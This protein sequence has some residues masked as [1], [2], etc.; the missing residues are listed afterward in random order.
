MKTNSTRITLGIAFGFLLSILMGIGW[1]GLS[2][3]DQINGDLHDVLDQH[4]AKVQL[5]REVE[6]YSNQNERIAMEIFF[7]DESHSASL[8]ARR[9]VNRSKLNNVL[10]ELGET[11]SSDKERELLVKLKEAREPLAKSFGRVGELLTHN[12]PTEARQEMVSETIPLR[13]QFYIARDSFVQ[14][15]EHEMN[16]AREASKLKYA[17]ARRI[18]ILLILL[19][20][21]VAAIIAVL[22]TGKM[23]REVAQRGIAERAIQTLNEELEKKV[24]GRTEQLAHTVQQLQGEVMERRQIEVALRQSE[25]NFRSMIENSPYGI[26]RITPDHRIQQANRALLDM[27]GYAAESEVVGMNTATHL[28]SS[29]AEHK[30]ITEQFNNQNE[31][32]GVEVEWKRKDGSPLTVRYG[33]HTVLDDS[34]NVHHKEIIAED[35]TER[36]ALEQQLRQAQKMEA[37]GQLAGGVA[38]DFNNLLGVIIGYSDLLLDRPDVDGAIRK[39]AAQIKKAGERASSLTR[40]LLAFSRRQVFESK[41]VSL[42]T[43]IA[44]MQKMLPRIIGEDIEMRTSFDPALGNVRADQGQIEQVIMNLAVNARDAMPK[45]GALIFETANVEVPE[46]FTS[47]HSGMIPGR[48]V[49]LTVSDTGVG[50]DA[51]ILSHMFEPF[52]TTKGP[53]RGT[54]LGLATVYGIIKQSGGYIWAD[55]DVGRGSRFRVYLPRIDKPV[56]Q[57]SFINDPKADVSSR[58]ETVLLVEDEESL[59]TL[60]RTLLQDA[61][62]AVLEA[63]NG[64]EATEIVRRHAEPIHLLLTDMV[65]PGINGRALAAKIT[66]MRPETKVVYMSGYTDFGN[67][68]FQGSEGD[69]LQKPFTRQGLLRKISE[70]LTLKAV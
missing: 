49:S 69:F 25:Q 6:A 43:I 22:V 54:G 4:W 20:I 7:L 67:T 65:M 2:R 1:L 61:G 50:M 14:F 55:S 35:I 11:A 24:A 40:Q 62:Y 5:A 39:Q 31:V 21:A 48:Y 47:S 34:G 27:L 32:K 64:G 30:R 12:R 63:S 15:V 13:A 70:V 18:E 9:N 53:G 58:S 19:A 45:G 60:T 57:D 41:I 10:K 52:F 59:R 26:F 17:E 37:V 33:R 56:L 66:A 44:E 8:L 16:D 42:N 51:N 28:F 23:T 29:V 46:A 38:H 36:R 3:M 68:G